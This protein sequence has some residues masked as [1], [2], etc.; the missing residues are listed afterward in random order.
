MAVTLQ[1]IA[2]EAGVSRGTVDRALNNR[3]RIRPEV[4]ENIKRIAEELGYQPSLA[5]RALVMARRKL[6]IGVILQSSETPF[7]KQVLGGIQA[8][9]QEVEKLGG[10]VDIEEI[11]EVNPKEAINRIIRM[12]D[13]P[14]HGI[15]LS[16]A[17]DQLLRRTVD[18]CVREYGIPV[19]TFN[20]D[21]DGTERMC[22]VGQDAGKSGVVA[23]GLMGEIV[24]EGT[25]AVISGHPT[26]PALN[27]R[28]CGF[29]RTLTE[30][31]PKA[32]V[33]ESRY[34]YDD[35]WVSEKMTEELIGNYPELNGIYVTGS[36]GVGVCRALERAGKSEKI[37]VIAN[38][39][40]ED[41]LNWLK[42]GVINF[43]IGQDA[44]VQG[45]EPVM[46]LFRKLFENMEPER[47]YHY[48][49]I[50]IKTKYNVE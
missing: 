18:E 37:K 24:G 11:E 48:T 31:C 35:D 2:Q 40:L 22:Y 7:M 43:L 32:N 17:E 45:Y 28:A 8:A 47:E 23:A 21:L 27:E 14:V 33:L 38:D 3:G 42:R 4:A 30:L 50:V 10:T 1:Q 41:N 15:A 34:A 13:E 25:V 16:G 5:G 29:C 26:N 44:Y 20:G 9:R 39:F 19:V 12:R 46:L 6:K 36:G 49:D